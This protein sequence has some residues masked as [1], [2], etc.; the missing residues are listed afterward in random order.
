MRR[1]VYFLTSWRMSSSASSCEV[2]LRITAE[3][4]H[5]R[6][7]FRSSWNVFDFFVVVFSK[8]LAPL[9][10]FSDWYDCYVY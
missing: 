1:M 7:Y 8:V 2:V 4:F 3:D 9:S 5:L 10:F 6:E